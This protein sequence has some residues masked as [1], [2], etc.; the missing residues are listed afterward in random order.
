MNNPPPNPVQESP[1]LRFKKLYP[2]AQIPKAWS[3]GAIG[4]DVHAYLLSEK[5]HAT[6]RVVPAHS[7]VNIGTGLL[8]EPPPG[9]FI[10]VCPRSGL[11]KYSI[12]V[13]NSPGIIDPDYRGEVRV[14][15]YNGGY[16]NFWVEHGM[17]IAQLVVMPV[18]RLPIVEAT[19]LSP[20]ERGERGF[21]STGS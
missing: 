3:P 19:I 12:S 13:T 16:D 21:G 8:I 2:Q 17:R 6:K 7:T 5:G 14:L 15:V 20:S 1:I 9:F 18:Y 10:F 11:G 4:Y